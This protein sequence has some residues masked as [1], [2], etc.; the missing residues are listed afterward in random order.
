MTK[1]VIPPIVNFVDPRRIP[2]DIM[3]DSRYNREHPDYDA[4]KEPEWL[5][6]LNEPDERSWLQKKKSRA[7]WLWRNRVRHWFRPGTYTY[8][9]AGYYHRLGRGWSEWDMDQFT[10]HVVDMLIAACDWHAT[11]SWTYPGFYTDMEAEYPNMEFKNERPED[12]G[13]GHEGYSEDLMRM[14]SGF[15]HFNLA[16]D[17]EKCTCCGDYCQRMECPIIVESWALFT[18]LFVHMWD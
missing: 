11:K 4:S 1:R 16:D 5:R 17:K 3:D 15:Q 13:R 9:L 14:K 10:P 8:K 7:K 2:Y 18:K 6:R 12:A